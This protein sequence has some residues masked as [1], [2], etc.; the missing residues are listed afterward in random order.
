MKK[1]LIFL[2]ISVS[3]IM[4][5]FALTGTILSGETIFQ[6]VVTNVLSPL[7]QLVAAIA[8]VYFLYGVAKFV[9]DLNDPEKKNFGKSHLFWGLI[10]IFIIFSIGGILP[11]LNGILGGMF[12]Y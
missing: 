4:T 2:L 11:F 5:S 3:E 10:G 8:F 7:Y 6:N 1:F 9:F 12:S